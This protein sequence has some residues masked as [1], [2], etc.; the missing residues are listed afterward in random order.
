MSHLE[1]VPRADDLYALLRG[2]ARSADVVRDEEARQLTPDHD[3]EGFC[4]PE[5][6]SRP[7]PWA[8][9]LIA[10]HSHILVLSLVWEKR[11]SEDPW[12]PV[13]RG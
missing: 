11:L 4:L 5:M 2:K 1:Q 3:C 10:E 8:S 13:Q 6:L 12:C 7:V 9:E